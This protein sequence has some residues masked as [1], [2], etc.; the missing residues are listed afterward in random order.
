M[1]ELEVGRL[2]PRACL[3]V[4]SW[5]FF[6]FC[7]SQSWQAF[8]FIVRVTSYKKRFFNTWCSSGTKT[9]GAK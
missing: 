9:L 2:A 3:S 6:S 7:S 4:P 5:L 1:I 8:T